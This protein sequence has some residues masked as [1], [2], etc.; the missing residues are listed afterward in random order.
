M[1]AWSA[2]SSHRCLGVAVRCCQRHRVR[3]RSQER[4][5]I[6]QR[7]RIWYRGARHDHRSRFDHVHDDRRSDPADPCPARGNNAATDSRSRNRATR[8]GGTGH[9]VDQHCTDDNPPTHHRPAG[10]DDHSSHLSATYHRPATTAGPKH[11]PHPDGDVLHADL[12]ATDH[13]PSAH[14]RTRYDHLSTDADDSLVDDH[15]PAGPNVVDRRRQELVNR[16]AVVGRRVTHLVCSGQRSGSTDRSTS[17]PRM[18]ATSVV[19]AAISTPSPSS[20]GV[21][22]RNSGSPSILTVSRCGSAP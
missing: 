17:S 1:V 18:H 8:Y 10:H 13:H 20:S 6:D 3:P 9:P 16:S 14:H 12:V 15:G 19:P 7:L 22:S 2:A 4:P 5:A 21:G 11:R